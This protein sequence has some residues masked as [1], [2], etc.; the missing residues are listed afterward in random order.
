MST[1][2]SALLTLSA[3]N[4]RPTPAE[5]SFLRRLMFEAPLCSSRHEL[6]ELAVEIAREFFRGV[7]SAVMRVDGSGRV[8][9]QAFSGIACC[10]LSSGDIDGRRKDPV[11]AAVLD[12]Q[13]AVHS[14]QLAP[15]EAAASAPIAEGFARSAGVFHDLAAPLYGNG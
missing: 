12:R 8:A 11:L 5:H 9:L 2:A 15:P 4:N 13:V 7:A 1:S 3:F 6:A 14:G 10:D